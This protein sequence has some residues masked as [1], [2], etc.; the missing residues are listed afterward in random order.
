VPL[1]FEII[2]HD[3]SPPGGW[4]Y[5]QPESGRHFRH[6]AYQAFLDQIRDHRLG[7][8]YPVSPDWIKEIENQMCL[9]HPEWGNT[10][11]RRTDA[12]SGT[13]RHSFAA[14]MSFF[15]MLGKWILSGLPHVEPEVAEERA[16]IC[17]TCPNNV[18]SEFGCGNCETK[19]Q[20]AISWLL[21]NRTTSI[22]DKLY[23]CGIC[24][25]NLKVAV[26]FPLGAQ[27]SNLTPEIKQ[28]LRDVPWCWKHFPNE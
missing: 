2:N 4:Y 8:E 17:A 27:E 23:S 21:G 20:K 16:K 28:E 11:C 24:S 6:Y 22:D 25:C 3:E 1:E 18:R 26:H 19:V 5:T 9:D 14:T 7:N 13:R 10:V 15:Q 12:R